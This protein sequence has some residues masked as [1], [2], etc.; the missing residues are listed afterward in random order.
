VSTHDVAYDER[1]VV[2]TWLW[3]ATLV[4]SLVLAAPV[5]GGAGGARAV[6][7]YVVAPLLALAALVAASRGRIRVADGM[8]HVPGARV[9]LSALGRPQALD[10]EQ[11]RR[12]RGPTA[13]LRAHV[14]ARPWLRRAVVVAVEDDDDDTPYWLVTTSRPEELA[15]AVERGR[16][17]S[18]G[19]APS[20]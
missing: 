10:V 17:S 6:V 3:P 4:L 1:L 5:H 9:P 12:L 15:A 7:P 19:R 20:T 14:A 13:D 2:P 18:G 16:L 11:T 8:L